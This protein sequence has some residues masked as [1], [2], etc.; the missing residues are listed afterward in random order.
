ML[1]AGRQ[2]DAGAAGRAGRGHRPAGGRGPGAR[3]RRPTCWSAGALAI[4]TTHYSELKAFAYATPGVENASVEFDVETL[5]PT[6]RLTIG[7]PGRSNALAIATRLGMQP[8]LVEAGP[9]LH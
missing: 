6:Y 3:H 7:L 9:Q 1:R 2:P 4:A 5:S 8:E